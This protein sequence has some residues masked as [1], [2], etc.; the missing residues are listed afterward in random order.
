VGLAVSQIATEV[1]RNDGIADAANISAFLDAQRPLDNSA[2]AGDDAR[3][4]LTPSGVVLIDESS[5]V[6]TGDLAAVRA[7]V[8]AAG[9]RMIL[10]GD[11]R[12]LG[13]VE[14]GGV[15]GLLDGHAETYHL[16]DVR[17][18][19]ERWER[20]AS[21]ALRDG[22]RDALLAYDRHG[23][24]TQHDGIDAA[25]DVAACAA[26]A[27][28]LD[29]RSV[30]V[31]AGT[32]AQAGRIAT[33]VRDQLV[34]LGLVASDGV[35]LGRD[36]GTAGVGDLIACRRND[37]TLGV[38]N[39][40]QYRVQSVLDDGSLVIEPLGGGPVQTF[41]PAYVAEDVQLGYASTVHAAQ[42]ITVDAAHLVTDGNLDA[43]ALYVGMTRG[44]LRNTA[45]VAVEP[46]APELPA[47]SGRH[48]GETASPA[49]HPGRA[50]YRSW[51]PAW[52]A[53][54]RA[55]PRPW[56]P[57]RTSP[58]PGR[59]SP[60]PGGW[61]PRPAWPAEPGWRPT[62]RPGRRRRPRLRDPCPA[63]RRPGQRVPLP[64]P[65][66]TEQAGD[67]PCTVL[68]DAVAGASTGRRGLGDAQT[69]AQ[70]LSYRITGGRELPLPAADAG[71]PAGVEARQAERLQHLADSVTAR[72]A[73]LGATVAAEAPTWAVLALGPVPVVDDASSDSAALADRADWER[74]AGIA[75]AHR[76]AVA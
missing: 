40:A 69:V 16:A 64:G 17:R 22:E 50:P 29:G 53:T 41:P 13:A 30:V 36:G 76:E 11:P 63:R 7:R 60:S 68:R 61:N 52:S 28:R 25:Q 18:F 47:A 9:A 24:L 55:S 8:E 74:C 71:L 5:M 43:P 10:T 62:R 70:V 56:P 14:A 4:Q 66:A 58:K 49:T 59:C 31:I 26:V 38:T 19:T 15:L 75:A 20:A 37:Y 42:G 35:P 73:E 21:L 45:H 32:N 23:R 12:Q 48:G 3:W 46:E 2:A 33:G 67:D 6:A 44:R 57:S 1:L 65:A 34:A 54:A 39:R 72:R 51:S 27:D